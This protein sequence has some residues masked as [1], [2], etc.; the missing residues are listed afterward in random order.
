MKRKIIAVL[1]GSMCLV[2]L[3]ATAQK[4][5]KPT[6]AQKQ[7]AYEALRK[8]TPQE[9]KEKFLKEHKRKPDF[10]GT[11]LPEKKS[12]KTMKT[13]GGGSILPPDARFPGEFEE[14]QGVFISWP[15]TYSGVP[16]IDTV[17][18]SPASKLYT[19]L[20]DGIQKAGVKLYINVWDGADTAAVKEFMVK[21][22]TPLTNYRFLVYEGDD[23]WARDFGPV[24]YYYD[25]DD[26]IGWVD[27]RYY[28]GRDFDNELPKL[29]GAELGIP[30]AFSNVFQEGGNI[31]TDGAQNSYT[32]DAVYGQN[33]SYNGYTTART[34]DS[35][36]SNLALNRLDVLKAL[37]HDGGT[38]HI[39]LYLDMTDEN[40]F[41]QTKMPIDMATVPGFTDYAITNRNID[42]LRKRNSFHSKPHHF[43]NIPFPT[44][45]DGSWYTTAGNYEFYTRTY[46]NHLIINK[47]II[48]PIFSDA[49]SGN[50]AGDAAAID[51][52]K[53]AY[54]GYKIIPIDMRYLDGSG[55][56]IHC[57]TKEMAAPNPIRFFHYA[58]RLKED[59]Q[60]SYPIDAI[61]TN[62]SG[63][64]SATLYWRLK[65]SSAWTSIP[66][67]SASG[68]HWLSN[69]PA[70]S[71]AVSEVFEYYI[72][73]T[74][75]NGKTITRPMPGAD[76]PY[77]FW[78]DNT[79]ASIKDKVPA[80][81]AIGN[82]YPNPAENIVNIE[83]VTSN[84]IDLSMNITDISGRI[85]AQK[86]FGTITNTQYLTLPTEHLSSGIFMINIINENG[87]I[88][89][90]KLIKK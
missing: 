79:P 21:K 24:N 37:P 17:S 39:D 77:E 88:A 43:F 40:T 28:P 20:A 22:G 61:I 46:S 51:S 30:V 33:T 10:T 11:I 31:L 90:R 76:G 55:G 59:Y 49:L 44:R 87:K 68:N 56:S 41:V 65:G 89:S 26:K 48:Q 5:I 80:G 2:N 82:L 23:I 50:A 9:M 83:V 25:T 15:Y 45:D 85:V 81:F 13:T 84:P 71:T 72:S 75:V 36:I 14:V 42:T 57:I 12:G 8:L 7:A 32:S 74:S 60:S 4:H 66:M 6:L 67:T 1:S 73:A 78:Y 63:I 34:K 47:T 58:Y 27:F 64:A 38:G 86:D 29:W 53:K 69:I 18:I 19:Q 35:L 54:P 62:H 70:S 52:I 3:N 16:V